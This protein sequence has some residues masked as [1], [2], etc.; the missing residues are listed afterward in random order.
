MELAQV[1]IWCPKQVKLKSRAL[2]QHSYK[3]SEYSANGT[4][5]D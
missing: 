2:L 4:E 3:A 5:K 1:G